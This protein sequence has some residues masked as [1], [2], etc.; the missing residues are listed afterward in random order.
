ML[1]SIGRERNHG[2]VPEPR[3]QQRPV[4]AQRVA[5]SRR[6]WLPFQMQ[7]RECRRQSF[8]RVSPLRSSPRRPAES[9]TASRSR[10]RTGEPPLPKA[11][12]AMLRLPPSDVASRLSYK[13][14]G[15]RPNC[16]WA[17][18]LSRVASEIPSP[19]AVNRAGPQCEYE[20]QRPRPQAL[21]HRRVTSTWHVRLRPPA[22]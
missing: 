21:G 7:A 22:A 17:V 5:A 11:P 13:L 12:R 4:R 18:T 20:Q 8:G 14:S 1:H 3:L 16:N 15:W 19:R 6:R 9:D 2:R 10:I